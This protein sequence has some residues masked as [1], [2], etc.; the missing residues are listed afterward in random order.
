MKSYKELLVEFIEWGKE[1]ASDFSIAEL[2]DGYHTFDELY[3]FRKM[4]NAA[5]FNEWVL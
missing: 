4:Y 1:N 3:E 2:S 5:L